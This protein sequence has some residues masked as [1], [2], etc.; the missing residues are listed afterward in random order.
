[1]YGYLHLFTNAFID[2]AFITFCYV[3]SILGSQTWGFL[4]GRVGNTAT[5]PLNLVLAT[6][7]SF[8][9]GSPPEAAIWVALIA[10]TLNT[11]LLARISSRLFDTEVFGYLAALAI[12]CNPLLIS[13]IGLEGL[14]VTLFIVATIYCYVCERWYWAAVVLGLQTL[15]RA[16][17]VLYFLV[18]LW[19]IPTNRLRLRCVALFSACIAPWYVFAW[20]YLGSVVPDT[21]II[22]INDNWPQG[23]FFNGLACYLR[24]YPV[25]TVLSFAFLP[26]LLV[27][28]HKKMWR[29]TTLKVEIQR[30]NSRLGR[31]SAAS[32]GASKRE[33]ARNA[34]VSHAAVPSGRDDPKNR[35]SQSSRWRWD[36]ANRVIRM[37]ALFGLIHFVAYSILHVP[38]YHWYYVPSVTC[39]VLLGSFALGVAYRTFRDGVWPRRLLLAVIVVYLATPLSGMFY[40]L[41]RDRFVVQQMPIHTNWA[42]HTQ[43][44]EIG[45][46]LKEHHQG[47]GI[48]VPGEVGTIA[49]YSDCYV[50]CFLSDRMWLK[51]YLKTIPPGVRSV[52]LGINYFFLG[53]VPKPM[54]CSYTLMAYD[55]DF[56]GHI[57]YPKWEISSQWNG[58]CLLVLKPRQRSPA[59]IGH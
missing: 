6:V 26:L 55:I 7:I 19:F 47:D 20:V 56:P 46:W 58:R 36:G 44:R 52:L 13:T 48:A 34:D 42:S 32:Q 40:L 45:L 10:L 37:V 59:P 8:F 50:L 18:F 23:H 2:D 4:P 39:I 29:N 31:K 28:F 33:T 17:G 54:P 27:Y 15:T 25:A 9:T 24:V 41:A 35:E 1:L 38:P 11:V 30:R 57:A 51:N 3:R 49:Y 14:L 43:Y 5:C 53:E 16:E 21:L 22:K 12:V